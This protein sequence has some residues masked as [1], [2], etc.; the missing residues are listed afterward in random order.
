MIYIYTGLAA[1]LLFFLYDINAARLHSGLLGSS[2]FI[3]CILLFGSTA[4][5]LSASLA[6][7]IITPFT[8]VCM[9]VAFVFFTLLVYT[10][11]VVLPFRNTY[12]ASPDTGEKQKVCSCGVYALSRHPGVLWFTGIYLFLSMAVPTPLV[13]KASITFCVC[14]ILY[15]IFQDLWTF[16]RTFTDYGR[17]KETVP[18]LFPTPESIR[19]CTDTL[20]SRKK[21]H[22]EV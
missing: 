3:G 13:L 21:E 6:Q 11:F 10:L 5:I 7:I 1:F 14:N 15:V 17:Y 8:V 19:R 12:L 16:P 18:F 20:N 2:F 4:G 9:I 22:N